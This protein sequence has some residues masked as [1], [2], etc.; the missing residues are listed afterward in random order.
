MAR[1]GPKGNL[2]TLAFKFSFWIFAGKPPGGGVPAWCH[3]LCGSHHRI[4]LRK[5][6]TAAS[7]GAKFG[8]SDPPIL[9]SLT[10]YLR[11]AKGLEGRSGDCWVPFPPGTRLVG[12]VYKTLQNRTRE[13]R[14]IWVAQRTFGAPCTCQPGEHRSNSWARDFLAARGIPW[15]DG[16]KG[17]TDPLK[18]FFPGNQLIG[19]CQIGKIRESAV[20]PMKGIPNGTS[21]T[22]G[23]IPL[24]GGNTA[25]G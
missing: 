21:Q 8:G 14:L 3:L 22:R 4:H 16:Q 6:L 10:Q 24:L 2:P 9:K 15:Q 20:A 7:G 1:G 18:A 13:N 19:V 12:Q 17:Q 5:E 23:T 25:A 11:A